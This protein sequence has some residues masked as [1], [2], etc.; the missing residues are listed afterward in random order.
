MA[1]LYYKTLREEILDQIRMRIVNQELK[2]GEKI[3]ETDL[4]NEFGVSRAPIRE[5]LR[6][7]EN[8]N[9]IEYVRNAGCSVKEVTAQDAY[10]IYLMRAHYEMLA[11]KILKGK[12]PR[13]T[14]Q[15]ME[16]LLERMANIK[17]EDYLDVFTLDN[18]F[19]GE[20]VKMVGLSRLY[21]EWKELNYGNIITSRKKNLNKSKVVKRQYAIH[22]PL[23]DVYK[24]GDCEKI[25]EAIYEH[26]HGTIEEM[27]SEEGKENEYI[28]A[29]HFPI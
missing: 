14:L 23:L 19:H 7:L 15:N 12:I 25:C 6:Q 28:H 18:E 13:E 11:V 17:E 10:E 1:P 24:T 26:Y 16:L 27:A 8:E 22:K 5:A 3:V 9:L 20:L 29:F 21:K 4:A 2:P